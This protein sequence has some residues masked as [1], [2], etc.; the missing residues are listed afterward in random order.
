MSAMK[1]RTHSRDFTNFDVD[2]KYSHDYD[3]DCVYVYV[4]IHHNHS[5]EYVYDDI[6][7]TLYVCVYKTLNHPKIDYNLEIA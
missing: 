2:C 5:L 7:H 4:D 3:D 6:H 1:K